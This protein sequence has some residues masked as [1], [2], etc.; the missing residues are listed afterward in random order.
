[1]TPNS[2]KILQR[3]GLPATLWQVAAEPTTL[4]VHRYS[5][6]VL[7]HE[8]RFDEHM[9]A[10]YGAPFLDMH[11]VDLQLALY[12]RARELGVAFRLGEL[13]EHIDFE[14]TEITTAVKSPSPSSSS[15][16]GGGGNGGN[17][18]GSGGT[19][20]RADIIVA[21]DGVW[22]RCQACYLGKDA[23]P[24]LPT[25]DLAYRIVMDL[26]QAAGDPVLADLIR[27]PAVHF[28]AGP[29]AH[30]VG[31][32]MRAGRMYNLVLLVPDDLPG[33]VSRQA[34]NVEEMKAIFAGWDPI[35][36]RFLDKVDRVEKWRLMHSRFFCLFSNT[37]GTEGDRYPFVCS[38]TGAVGLV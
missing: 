33:D 28:W 35:L 3:W 12:A 36:R 32:S 7:A 25:G 21:A 22:S 19:K 9:R 24:P 38:L 16:N 10:R 13:V 30:A 17:G 20:A 5:G 18:S 4:T 14:R 37:L 27:H 1:M 34:G 15:S 6:A 29:G 11:R 31:Y 23:R 8:D 26:D 2:T